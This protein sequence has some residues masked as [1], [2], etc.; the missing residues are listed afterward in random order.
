M[1]HCVAR[2]LASR[3]DRA[4]DGAKGAVCSAA[5]VREIEAAIAN[6]TRLLAVTEDPRAAAGLVRERA[7]LR[8][9]LHRE[10]REPTLVDEPQARAT[11]AR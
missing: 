7:V 6:L 3:H 9:E 11:R 8:E 4:R 2:E 5:R 1:A 10:V